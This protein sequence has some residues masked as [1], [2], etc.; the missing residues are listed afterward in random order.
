MRTS[1]LCTQGRWVSGSKVATVGIPT[2]Q[3]R[4]D[5]P[6]ALLLEGG[7]LHN[8]PPPAVHL[9]YSHT[10][11]QKRDTVRVRP[12]GAPWGRHLPQLHVLPSVGLIG[13]LHVGEL[14]VEGL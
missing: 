6:G 5:K 10:E 14:K 13:L 11:P 1:Q 4:T 9:P 7:P 2:L 3:K 8:P 12:H